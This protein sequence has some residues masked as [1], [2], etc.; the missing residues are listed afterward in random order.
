MAI[1]M[2]MYVLIK[3]R[4]KKFGG[5]KPTP[6]GKVSK[7]LIDPEPPVLG[8]EFQCGSFI[9]RRVVKELDSN[10]YFETTH[11]VYKLEEI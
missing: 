3:T 5:S 7:G 4:H 6:L 9:T 2:K 10:G 11:S 1:K 8:R